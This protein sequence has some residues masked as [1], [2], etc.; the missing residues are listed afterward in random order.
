MGRFRTISYKAET[1]SYNDYYEKKDSGTMLKYARSIVNTKKMTDNFSICCSNCTPVRS[2]QC[3]IAVFQSYASLI[4]LLKRQAHL[5]NKCTS[6][7]DVPLTLMNGLK[8]EICIKDFY[9]SVDQYTN[10]DCEKLKLQD[11]N[12]CTEKLGNLFP[13]GYYNNNS[14][15]PNISLKRKLYLT[16]DKKKPCPTYIFCK[17]P[18]DAPSCKCCDY[19]V[20]FPFNNTFLSYKISGCQTPELYEYFN[21]PTNNPSKTY[22]IHQG[23]IH[24]GKAIQK[25]SEYAFSKY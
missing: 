20:V 17:C 2:N 18:A 6:C 9:K 12:K 5:D 11:V 23:N 15:T 24:R 25:M 7:K 22:E 8:S 4:K 14:K 3:Y 10:S 1:D 16:C 13:Y 19:N 21:N